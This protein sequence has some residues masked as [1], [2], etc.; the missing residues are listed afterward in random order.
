MTGALLGFAAASILIVLLPGP[1]TLVVVRNLLRGGRR[2]AAATAAGVCTGLTVWAI[3]ATLGVSA[4]LR[5]SHT[6]YDVLRIVGGAYLVFIG[7]QS[8]R[9]R[10]A[11][12][13][14]E[15]RRRGSL[16]GSGYIAG[17]ATDLL[18]PKV[19]VFFVT[20]LPAFVPRGS[21]V[22]WVTLALGLVFMLETALYFAVLVGIADRVVSWMTNARTR[23][24]LDRATGLVFIGFG[25]RLASEQA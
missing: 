20:F 17:L 2:R 1:D 6:G 15:P 5:A 24:R 7:V 18:N 25:L 9:G 14:E 11:P 10:S 12:L 22:G 19:G 21:A 13:G 4:L 16:V 8:L 3:A 23:K